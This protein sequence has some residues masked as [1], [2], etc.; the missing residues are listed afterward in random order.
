MKEIHKIAALVVEN[1]SFL[2]VRKAGKD[3]WTG[4]GGKPEGNETEEEAL[5][6]E[7]KEELDCGAKIIRKIG[8]FKSK[9][10][11]DDAIVKLSWYLVELIGNP[12]ISDPELEEFGFIPKDYKEKGIKLPPSLE[13]Q[14]LPFCI[15]EGI[16]K[17]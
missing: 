14:L 16:L 7:I 6:R 5:L 1:N 2:M 8:D 11:F 4:L 17:W 13:E 3:I 12:K 9:A 10:I 15:K